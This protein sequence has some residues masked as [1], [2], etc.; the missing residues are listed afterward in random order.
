MTM[1]ESKRRK[2]ELGENYGKSEPIV[3]WLP[4]WTKQKADRFVQIT[5]TGAWVGIGVMVAYWV[6]VRFIGPTFG[7]WQVY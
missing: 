7:W 5:T 3:P 2:A 4:F 1:G 6:A